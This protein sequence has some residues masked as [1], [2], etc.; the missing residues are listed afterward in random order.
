MTGT[1]HREGG[2]CL[3]AAC[4]PET[5]EETMGAEQTLVRIEHS[6]CDEYDGTEY[7]LAPAG[8][9]EARI[10]AEINTVEQEMIADAQALKEPPF[11]EPPF[12]PP[13]EKHPQLTV[14][15]V[16]EQHTKLKADYKAWR[17]ENKQMTRSFADR[18]RDRGFI[19]L[20][21]D[22]AEVLEHDCYWG[23][24]HGLDLNYKHAV[25]L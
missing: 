7:V 5:Q 11:G 6:R 2:G 17:D 14:R 13:Y 19:G 24:R 8:W 12:H 20:W 21:E 9:D 23:H 16:Q 15:E 18:L 22:E 25:T 3:R 4:E 1:I 10:H